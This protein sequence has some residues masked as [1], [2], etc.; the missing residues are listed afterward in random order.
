MK[1]V[2]V[3]IKYF[4]H[5][6]QTLIMRIYY[7][8]SICLITSFLMF[9]QQFDVSGLVV[10]EKTNNPLSFS[11]IRV[12]GTTNGTAANKDGHFNLKLSE[13]NYTLIASYIGFVSDTI[14]IKLSKDISDLTFR[15]KETKLSLPEILVKPGINPALEIIRKAIDRK[16]LRNEKL[17]SYEFDAYTKGLIRT[18]G[19]IQAGRSNISLNVGSSDTS[20]LKI[21]GILENQ[22]RGY[23][24]KPNSYKEIILA[25]KQSANFPPSINILTGGRLIQNFYSDDINFFSRDI[26]GPISTNALDYYDYFIEQTL[27]QDNLKIFKIYLQTLSRSNPGFEGYIYLTDKTFDLLK[28][29]LQLNKAA[30]FGGLF[31]T[32]NVFQQFS[33]FGN[34]ISMPVDYRLFV[35][36]N[37]LGIA[38]FGFELNTIL[39]DY[40]INDQIDDDIFNKAIVTVLPDAD[41]KD[42][43]YWQNIQSIP[44]T[45]EE[46]LAYK[47]IDSLKNLPRNFWDD[48]SLLSTRINISENLSISAP[49]TM[50][51]FNP[52]EGHSIDFGLFLDQAI[53]QR[54]NSNL[55]LSY[56]FSDK[57]LKSEISLKYLLGDYR[58]YGAA[59]SAFDKTKILFGE[60]D[61]YNELTSTLLALLSKYSFRN[62][63]YSN[64]FS[65]NFLGEVAPILMLGLGFENRTDNS[66][67]NRSDFSFFVKEKSYDI[68]STIDNLRMNIITASIKIDPRNYIE[69]GL[70]RRRVSMGKS[71]FT[72]EGSLSYS[73][74]SFLKSEANFR[75]YDLT[76]NSVISSFGSTRLDLKLYG[77]YNDGNLPFQLLYSAPGNFDLAFKSFSFRTLKL[78]EV[79]SDRALALNAEYN[80]RDEL[81]KLLKIPGLK[82]WGIQLTAFLNGL[83]T[84]P[85]SEVRA[86]RLFNS[87]IYLN[88][89]YEAGFSLGHVLIPLQIEFAWKLNHRGENNFRVGLN[90][91]VF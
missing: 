63:Y 85:S 78:N 11:N 6:G 46:E 70:F 57:K 21:T 7:T 50:Y 88:P 36:A 77:F 84:N 65:I 91:F 3:Y 14:N 16:K 75:K 31:D 5:V 71:Y 10:N 89:F 58:T 62:Y 52:V 9:G 30:N 48:F 1:K 81:F 33:L 83:Y 60:S 64:G 80:F 4:L 25:R 19:E 22:S 32:V 26:P 82:D 37:Y 23:F 8:I 29:D 87:K 68:N 28:V 72:L 61:N 39:Y 45:N 51:H 34:S 56:G 2:Y 90:T 66:A 55:S 40:K 43:L 69:D 17:R 24:Q 41:K 27:A 74:S 15:L 18:Q 38:K 59:F 13:G 47:R 49:L 76:F 73:N 79:L 35:N 42:S 20:E 53:E 54:L 12:A 86:N 67:I 44:N